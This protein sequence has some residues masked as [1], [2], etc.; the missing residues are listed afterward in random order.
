MGLFSSSS[1]EI[2]QSC[3]YI[4]RRQP[5]TYEAVKILSPAQCTV[6]YAAIS[7]RRSVSGHFEIL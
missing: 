5:R 4:E 3:H 2:E 6:V 7:P 1:G